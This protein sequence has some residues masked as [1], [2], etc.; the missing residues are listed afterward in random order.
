MTSAF[1]ETMGMIKIEHS[2]FAMPFALVAAFWAAQGWPSLPVLGLILLA[3]VFARSASMAFNR[4]LDADIDGRNP[5][6]ASR[7]IPAGRLSKGYALGFSM[8]CALLFGIVC[9]FIN[10]LALML[11]PIFLLVLL[12]Y[13]WSKRFTS[14]CHLLL[15][16]AL[17][18]AP[19]G[20]WVAVTGQLSWVPVWL[21][22]AVMGWT[23][24]FDVIYACQDF[25]FDRREGL[26]SIP[27]RLGVA[28]ALLLSRI[29]HCG[30]LILLIYLGVHLHQGLLYWLG[31]AMVTLL[32]VYEHGLVWGGNLSKVN[33]AF[34]TLNG[35]V[36][37]LFGTMTIIGVILTP[38]AVAI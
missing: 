4:Y 16:L 35:M 14:L 1:S 28:G 30:M 25:E 21:G 3:M 24:G 36:S 7:A 11:S 13:S 27:A 8:I 18:L 6:T 15:G 31:I 32:L 9:G 20:A 12:G 5:R 17:G 26:F 37:L 2:I 19:I 33:M 34:F 10:P 38:E 23:A 29:L 22:M